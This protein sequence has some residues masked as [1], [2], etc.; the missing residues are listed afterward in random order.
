MSLR[1]AAQPIVGHIPLPILL[2]SAVASAVLMSA[3]H[4]QGYPLYVVAVFGLSPWVPVLVFETLWQYRQY[5]WLAAFFVITVL[6][7]GHLGE[8]AVQVTQLFLNDGRLVHSHG[9]FGQLDFETVHFFWDSAVWL[10]TLLLVYRFG[11]Q[12]V[13]L[14]V[15]L[16]FA[17]LHEVEHMYLYYVSLFEMGFYHDHGG[18]AGILGKGGIL[19]TVSRPY[20]HFGY[21]F[22]VVVPMVIAYCYQLATSIR[23]AQSGHKGMPDTQ[24]AIERRLTALLA[25][26]GD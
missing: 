7:V 21:N 20:L 8:H 12:N 22:M 1:R 24:T 19:P 6:Q 15:S 13:W 14:W 2:V 26:P 23:S 25:R 3:A 16:L 18:F 4:M 11:R 5:N 9:V 17:S 10:G